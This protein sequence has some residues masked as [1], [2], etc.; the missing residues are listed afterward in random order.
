MPLGAAKPARRVGSLKLACDRVQVKID[1]LH[2]QPVKPLGPAS[3]GVFAF[4]EHLSCPGRPV[5]LDDLAEFIARRQHG[6]GR[7]EQRCDLPWVLHPVKD[8]PQ[9][10]ACGLRPSRT[11]QDAAHCVAGRDDI[12][13]VG[14]ARPCKAPRVVLPDFRRGRP[15][16]QAGE[17]FTQGRDFVWFVGHDGSGNGH[18][19]PLSQ[20]DELIA[21]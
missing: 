6:I 15:L 13:R 4:G 18:S 12:K 14:V 17:Q 9:D 5:W 2:G 11:T 21:C 1:D 8:S 19:R 16:L 3:H 10:T 20:N 7:C